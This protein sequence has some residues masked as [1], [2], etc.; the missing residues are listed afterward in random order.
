MTL[1]MAGPAAT[2]EYMLYLPST[3]HPSNLSDVKWRFG[4]MWPKCPAIRFLVWLSGFKNIIETYFYVKSLA[5]RSLPLHSG[6]RNQTRRISSLHYVFCPAS[7]A[8]K[9]SLVF[10]PKYP[11][12]CFLPRLSGFRNHTQRMSPLH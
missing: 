9:T 5:F 8:S 11:A 4:L 7:L 10:L 1:P 6:F 12:L 3:R 2:H